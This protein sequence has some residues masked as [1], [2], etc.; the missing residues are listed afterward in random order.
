MQ[1]VRIQFE[2]RCSHGGMSRSHLV[3]LQSA[4][5]EEL[6]TGRDSLYQAFLAAGKTCD[7]CDEPFDHVFSLVATRGQDKM[8]QAVRSEQDFENFFHDAFF[9][10]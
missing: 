7:A 1:G 4:A 6:E 9:Y 10:P 8:L 3:L 5:P 2:E